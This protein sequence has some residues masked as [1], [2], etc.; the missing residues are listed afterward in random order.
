MQQALH[1]PARQRALLG[2]D[3]GPVFDMDAFQIGHQLRH[4]HHQVAVVQAAGQFG[5]ED[6]CGARFSRFVQQVIDHGEVVVFYLCFMDGEGVRHVDG[7]IA[8]GQ[9]V[10]G[11]HAAKQG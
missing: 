1:H 11:D 8:A 6:A 3:V 9:H 5:I 4:V 2:G 10:R 7:G